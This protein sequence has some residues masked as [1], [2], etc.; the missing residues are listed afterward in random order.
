VAS[1]CSIERAWG[2]YGF[3]YERVGVDGRVAVVPTLG[4]AGYRT[5]TSGCVSQTG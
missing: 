3:A 5:G 2:T 1:R 4:S